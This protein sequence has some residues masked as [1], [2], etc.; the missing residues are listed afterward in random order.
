MNFDS[1]ITFLP[2]RDLDATRV[3][4]VDKLG[5][6]EV[7]DQ[8]VCAIFEVRPGCYWGFCSHIE[9]TAD[10]NRVILTVVT[11]FVDDVYEEFVGKDIRTDG[12]PRLNER[13]QIYH[14][15][16]TDPDGHRI[17]VQQFRDPNWPGINP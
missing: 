16:A 1:G 5:L 4:Y 14:F 7:L 6:R 11:D 2:V 10:S 9:P 3:F 15:F 12:K 8:G 13:F 17:E